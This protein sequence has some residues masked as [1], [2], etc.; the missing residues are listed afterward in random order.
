SVRSALPGLRCV[1]LAQSDRVVASVLRVG[2]GQ[3]GRLDRAVAF[4]DVLDLEELDGLRHPLEPAR[5]KAGALE[6]PPDQSVG[7]LA[8]KDLAG[9]RDV[10]QPDGQVPRLPHQRYHIVLCLDD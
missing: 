8:T 9:R 6:L 7:G 3:P 1:I 4:A 2:P 10:L 5:A